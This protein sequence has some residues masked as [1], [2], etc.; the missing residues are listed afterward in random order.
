M[1][2]VCRINSQSIEPYAEELRQKVCAECEN[3]D[4]QQVCKIRDGDELV[5]DWCILDAYFGLV[6][7]SIERVQEAHVSGAGNGEKS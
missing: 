1:E 7:G 6:V 5:P 4:D 2:V 3:Q